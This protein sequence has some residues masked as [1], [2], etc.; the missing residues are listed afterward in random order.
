VGV[1]RHRSRSNGPATGGLALAITPGGH[2]VVRGVDGGGGEGDPIDAGAATRIAAAFAAGTGTGLVQLGTA[3]VETPLPAALGFWRDLATRYVAAVCARG[4]DA[5]A[6]VP[7]PDDAALAAIAAGAPPMTG[8]EYI[9]AALLAAQWRA[10]DEAFAAAV[11]GG[12]VG[13]FLRARHAAWNLVGRVHFNLAE[14][15]GDDEAPFAFLATYTT[16]LTARATA[17]HV[18]LG[19]LGTES[20]VSA[21]ICYLLSPAAAFVSGSCIRVDGAV[22]NGKKLMEISNHRPTPA[23]EGFHLAS[24]PKVLG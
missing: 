9:D 6:P 2:L 13:A 5:G 15:R 19:R 21:A 23:Y 16:R 12:D 4:E 24:K 1:P 7:P 17:Q 11:G 8:G 18:P 3:E 10:L 20:E 22:P 14:N